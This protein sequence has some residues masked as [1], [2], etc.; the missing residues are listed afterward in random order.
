MSFGVNITEAELSFAQPICMTQSITLDEYGTLF[1][2]FCKNLSS[3]NLLHH[4][5]K[6]VSAPCAQ[7]R[8]E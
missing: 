1:T 7:L 5:A 2:K 3:D 8:V 4:A 6:I